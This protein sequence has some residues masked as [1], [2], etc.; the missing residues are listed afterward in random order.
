M[1]DPVVEASSLGSLITV[2]IAASTTIKRGE[3]VAD[4]GTNTVKS[5]AT[6][7]TLNP[8][9][10]AVSDGGAGDT[11]TVALNGVLVDSDAPFTRGAPV[12]ASAATAGAITSTRPTTVTNHADI[13][14]WAVST[15]RVVFSIPPKVRLESSH[16][17]TARGLEIGNSQA[18]GTTQ[19]TNE[20]VFQ[21]GT[22]PVGTLT[23]GCAIFT[24]G[25]V[26]RKII[27]ANTA[28]N[29]ET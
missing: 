21:S 17:F 7:D 25:T 15:S 11:I 14:G 6:D 2:V 28:S 16:V 13:I 10:I 20:V 24:D 26:M 4:N 18:F 23:T 1:A 9:G 22:A 27:A 19:G 29:I 3:L 8:I 12:Y 5:N